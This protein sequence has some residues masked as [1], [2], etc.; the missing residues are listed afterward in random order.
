MTVESSVL[1]ISRAEG[2]AATRRAAGHRGAWPSFLRSL[3]ARG[4]SAA[5]LVSYAHPGLVDAIAELVGDGGEGASVTP[6]P[7]QRSCF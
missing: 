3:V 1:L 6:R 5:E 7:N 4:L 2:S